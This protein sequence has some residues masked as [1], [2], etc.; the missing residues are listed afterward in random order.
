MF[1]AGQKVKFTK[2][3]SDKVKPNHGVVYEDAEIEKAPQGFVW[4][5]FDVAAPPANV[6]LVPEDKLEKCK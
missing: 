5:H 1:K 2:E 6:L 3:W 4:V